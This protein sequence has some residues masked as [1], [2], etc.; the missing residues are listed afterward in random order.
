MERCDEI[1]R[2]AVH[3]DGVICDTF[4]VAVQEKPSEELSF[5]VKFQASHHFFYF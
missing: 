3:R 4:G 1:L 5:L 2:G